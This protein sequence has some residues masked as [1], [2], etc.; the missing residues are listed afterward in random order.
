ME[1]D[2]AFKLFE[3]LEEINARE[4]KTRVGKRRL[5]ALVVRLV[6]GVEKR[7][8]RGKPPSSPD[9]RRWSVRVSASA[10]NV[11]WRQVLKIADRHNA[12]A[13][14]ENAGFEFV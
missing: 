7:D 8:E 10:P 6:A 14:I 12:E 2:A 9:H 3:G 5:P 4:W 1:K 11:D 13:R